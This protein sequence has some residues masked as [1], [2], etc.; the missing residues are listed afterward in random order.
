V[1]RWRVPAGGAVAALL[2]VAIDLLGFHQPRSREIA[3]LHSDTRRL[4]SEQV[5]LERTIAAL[6][7][8]K[9]REPELRTAL[10][11]LDTLIPPHL[12]QP[13]LLAQM[14]GAA[15]G[16]G[17]ELVSVTF[18]DP[19]VPKEAPA[20]AIP[21]AVL[22]SM[23]LTV[24]VRG[25]YAGITNLLRRIE[26]EKNRA[27]LVRTVAVTESDAGFPQLT[28]TWSGEAYALLAAA[29]PVLLD[30]SDLVKKQTT[31]TTTADPAGA[32]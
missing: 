4:R 27:V 5:A 29:N 7:N 6:E 10:Q 3:T 17:V 11:L 8:V 26:T 2:L 22:V 18:G 19:T 32:K 9:A 23:P 30:P 20:S 12:A 28:G 13:A 1:R 21:D 25:P 16:A 15:Q 31:T 24:V 14:Q